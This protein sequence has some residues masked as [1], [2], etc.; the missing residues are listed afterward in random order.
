LEAEVYLEGD[1]V[2]RSNES[3]PVDLQ[4]TGVGKVAVDG[5][6]LGAPN[7]AVRCAYGSVT[8]QIEGQSPFLPNKSREYDDE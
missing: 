6:N 7:I 5:L 2:L 1:Y 3:F 8:E 4:R